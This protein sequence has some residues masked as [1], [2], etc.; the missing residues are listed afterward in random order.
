MP[1]LK[2][3]RHSNKL[4]SRDVCSNQDAPT[5]HQSIYFLPEES[6]AVLSLPFLFLWKEE[7]QTTRSTINPDY[8]EID[9]L[10]SRNCSLQL[11]LCFNLDLYNFV[12]C[13]YSEVCMYTTRLLL[14]SS[15]VD[16][17]L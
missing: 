10:K 4:F 9:S 6:F 8:H 16:I 15:K 17:F 2:R 5:A 13:F 11:N 14:N 3:T 7:S 12:M 1:I